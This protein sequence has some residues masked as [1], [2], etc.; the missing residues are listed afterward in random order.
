MELK[1]TYTQTSSK[2]H[3]L[4]NI[5]QRLIGSYENFD[6]RLVNLEKK[7]TDLSYKISLI[8]DRIKNV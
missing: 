5:A 8:V 6:F 4:W 2:I 7:F 3:I 1:K